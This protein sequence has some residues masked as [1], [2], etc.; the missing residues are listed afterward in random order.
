MVLEESGG[1][2]TVLTRFLAGWDAARDCSSCEL[3]E[4]EEGKF[5]QQAETLAAVCR[6]Q[7]EHGLIE[8]FSVAQVATAGA[9]HLCPSSRLSSP[10]P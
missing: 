2:A 7:D 8:T 1:A 3:A 5:T 6:L 4:V 9:Q 10:S